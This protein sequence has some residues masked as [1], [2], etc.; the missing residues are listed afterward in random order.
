MSFRLSKCET[1]TKFKNLNK[2][3]WAVCNKHP[4]Y[5]PDKYFQVDIDAKSSVCENY[6]Y[7]PKWSEKYDN[8]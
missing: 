8:G 2:A 6:E 3:P 5:I 4:D 1:C 7:N